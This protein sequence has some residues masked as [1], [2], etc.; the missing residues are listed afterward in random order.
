MS[1]WKFESMNGFD[2]VER[3]AVLRHKEDMTRFFVVQNYGTF[4]VGV[5]DRGFIRAVHNSQEWWVL[6][7]F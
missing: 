7:E 2:K 5:N 4:L 1:N 3:G 6:K